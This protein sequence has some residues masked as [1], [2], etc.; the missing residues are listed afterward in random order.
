MLRTASPSNQTR[1]GNEKKETHTVFCSDQP[2]A[3]V[4]NAFAAE[5]RT[6]NM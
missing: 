1:L 5:R 6:R 4:A 2:E 3:D